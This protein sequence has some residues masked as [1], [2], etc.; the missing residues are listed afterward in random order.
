MAKA[1]KKSDPFKKSPAEKARLNKLA[2][3]LQEKL[4]KFAGPNGPKIDVIF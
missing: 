4:R 1:K 2:A 3:E